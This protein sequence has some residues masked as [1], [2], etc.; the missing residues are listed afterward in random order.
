MD[1]PVDFILWRSKPT[2]SAKKLKGSMDF[3]S[4]CSDLTRV[5]HPKCWFSNGSPLILGKPRLVKYY[6]LARCMVCLPTFA[7]K[8]INHSYTGTC[9]P[10][11]DPTERD[12]AMF[13]VVLLCNQQMNGFDHFPSEMV[14][15][16]GRKPW[17]LS[18]QLP[19]MKIVSW[20]E[21]HGIPKNKHA[22]GAL[23]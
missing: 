20:L 6:N 23:E 4:N 7:T 11:M 9:I 3:W 12:W 17:V 10:Y 18:A 19:V 14:R 13:I 16:N 2:I 22:I 1:I 8:K 15:T 21:F 5:F